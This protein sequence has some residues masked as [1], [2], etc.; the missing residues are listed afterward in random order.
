[1]I[2]LV[3][4]I[5]DQTLFEFHLFQDFL[6]F[7]FQSDNPMF[8][9]HILVDDFSVFFSDQREFLAGKFQLFDFGIHQFNFVLFLPDCGIFFFHFWQ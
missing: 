8:Q 6:V 3:L 2:E 4:F 9:G 5:T 7:I 1:M